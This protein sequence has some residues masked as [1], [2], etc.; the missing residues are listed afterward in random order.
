M[1]VLDRMI[2]PVFPGWA[3][4]RMIARANLATIAGRARSHAGGPDINDQKARADASR[5]VGTV[6][7]DIERDRAGDL[8][9]ARHLIARNG[10][11]RGA[12]NSITGNV[13]GRGMKPESGIE[14]RS[15][16]QKGLP[17]DRENDAVE[18][19]FTRWAK[20]CDLTGKR[21]FR[22]LQRQV[23]RER[24]IANDVFIRRHTVEREIPLALE[25]VG[26]ELLADITDQQNLWHG[27]ELDDKRREIVAYH[28]YRSEE[29]AEIDRVPAE[30][31]IHIF[32]PHRP[33]AVRGISPMAPVSSAFEAL[34]RYLNHELTRAGV[35]ASLLALHK[36]GG[37][38]IRGLA[39]SKS[40][41]SED[42]F[43][44]AVLQLMD[45]GVMLLK[46]GLNDSLETAAPSIQ[47]TAFDP[48]VRLILRYIAT[49]LGVSYELIARDF[50]G[51]NFSSA[52]QANLEDRRQWEPE[53]EE[54]IEEFLDPVWAWFVDAAS[55]ARVAPFGSARTEWPV[56]WTPQGWLWVDPQKEITAT[57]TAIGLGIDNPIDA[58]RRVGRD[59]HEN[60]KKIAAANQFAESLG[61]T[62]GAAGTA[63]PPEEEEE[64]EEEEVETDDVDDE[65]EEE[66]AE[67]STGPSAAAA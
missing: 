5:S 30:Q 66:E 9:V 19:V 67:G 27:I 23:Y 12:V 58:A 46:G 65:D 11:A 18:A 6:S 39:T 47:S 56:I 20:G 24:W 2:A 14:V 21:S 16:P 10:W 61:V 52:R 26:A 35:A 31:V 53:Q 33:G 22:F 63:P 13:I 60:V 62:L 17:A 45:G 41:S 50:T 32:K 48:F 40:G 42:T 36:T 49:S 43:G 1:N 51:T 8:K 55:F 38:G 3:L 28:F 34:R 25:V 57:E 15:G 4:S 54:F 37:A 44:N 59:F 29:V 7:Q 64:E